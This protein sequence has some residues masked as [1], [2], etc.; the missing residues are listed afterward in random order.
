MHSYFQDKVRKGAY[1]VFQ[2]GWVADYPDPENFLFLL[3]GP[4][5][6]TRSG[7]PNTANF[8]A[9]WKSHRESPREDPG[10]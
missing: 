2:W 8:A 5:A 9:H 10:D 3:Y 7:G 4:M 1:Q 6:R